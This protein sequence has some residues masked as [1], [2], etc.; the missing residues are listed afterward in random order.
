M[1]Y[2]DGL[3]NVTPTKYQMLKVRW[4]GFYVNKM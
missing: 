4:S 3:W 1:V 2:G